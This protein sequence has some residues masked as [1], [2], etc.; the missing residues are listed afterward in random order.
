MNCAPGIFL[1]LTKDNA[2]FMFLANV[3]AGLDFL[4]IDRI[5]A[6]TAIYNV[7]RNLVARVYRLIDKSGDVQENFGSASVFFNEAVT[8]CRIEK[9][10]NTCFHTS[11][12]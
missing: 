6:F 10:N 7:E 3:N 11:K 8:F 12:N 5:D 9:F 2:I 4:D 1:G